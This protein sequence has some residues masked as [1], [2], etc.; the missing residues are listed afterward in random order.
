MTYRR[1]ESLAEFIYRNL[2]FAHHVALMGLEATGFAK[3]N[4]EALW[5]DPWE[6]REELERATLFLAERRMHVSIYN[7]QLCTVTPAV[8][9][10]CRQSISDWKNEYLPLCEG[11]AARTSCGGFFSFN[12]KGHVSRHLAPVMASVVP[13]VTPDGSPPAHIS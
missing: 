2:T 12:V 13:A 10:Y 1:L 8:W 11:C 4:M 5:I 7:H 9:P 3:G 6:Y